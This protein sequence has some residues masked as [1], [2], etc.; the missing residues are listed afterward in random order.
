MKSCPVRVRSEAEPACLADCHFLA[1]RRTEIEKLELYKAGFAHEQNSTIG[2]ARFA[3]NHLMGTVDF[4]IRAQ[5]HLMATAYESCALPKEPNLLK[6][7]G[8]KTMN[9][10]SP[11]AH[12]YDQS[13]SPT[14]DLDI[15]TMPKHPL[16]QGFIDSVVEVQA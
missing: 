6:R 8:R 5:E 16:A 14:D 7:I 15:L 3:L 4:L 11:A 13:Y 12:N 10:T 2:P 9:C 1:E